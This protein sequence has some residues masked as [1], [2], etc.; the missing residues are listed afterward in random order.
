MK[1]PQHILAVEAFPFVKQLGLRNGFNRVREQEFIDATRLHLISGLRDILDNRKTGREEIVG[2]IDYLANLHGIELDYKSVPPINY[3]GDRTKLQLLPY[4]VLRFIIDGVYFYFMYQRGKGVGESRLAGNDSVGYG[5][6]VDHADLLT[7]GDMKLLAS[8]QGEEIDEI[9]EE[10]HSTVDVISTL[11][12][13]GDREFEQEVILRDAE[14][15]DVTRKLMPVL[16]QRFE[17]LI[18]DQSNDVGHLHLGIVS[19]IDIPEGITAVP[20]EAQL[21]PRLSMTA[22]EILANPA[23]ESWTKIVAKAMLDEA[24]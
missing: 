2:L 11:T 20:R 3:L 12:L 23:A 10:E 24:A 14:G 22:D 8:E 5:G 1:H 6:H 16:F 21:L 4:R 15:N 18:W 13:A 9:T 7:I 17:G 19:I